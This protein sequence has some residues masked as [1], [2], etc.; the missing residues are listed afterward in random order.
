MSRKLLIGVTGSIAAYKACD[1]VSLLAQRGHQVKVIMTEN[2]RNFVAPLALET[3]SRN[4]VHVGQFQQGGDGVEHIAL[5]RWAD[6]VCIAPA[7]ADFICKYAAGFADN[8]LLTE[9][10]AFTG[11]VLIAPA[12]NHAMYESFQV[13]QAIG[14]LQRQGVGFIDP[15]AGLL[16]CGETGIG[17]MA[18]VETVAETIETTLRRQQLLAGKNVVV[19]AGPTRAYIDPVRFLSN[20]SSGRMGYALANAATAMG[21]DVTLVSGP[22]DPTLKF[23]KDIRVE[24]AEQMWQATEML[25][26]NSEIDMFVGAAAVNDLKP[27]QTAERKLPKA[28]MPQALSLTPE[29]DVI[30]KVAASARRP[31]L[32]V[33]FA[34]ETDTDFVSKAAQKLAA[35]RLDYIIANQV[36]VAGQ[37]FGSADNAVTVVSRHGEPKEFVKTDKRLLAGNL[38]EWIYADHR[39]RRGVSAPDLQ[40][41]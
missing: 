12:M 33:G 6:I 11:Q 3:L 7:S 20:P 41:L 1:L 25:L 22:C 34:A 30:A 14:T 15:Y 23:K 24:T 2:A 8:L 35:K 4:P 38:L 5:A 27:S 36:G 31:R 16:A 19:T 26:H 9:L 29:I 37:G 40:I 10:L 18:T 17:K 21:A 13:Q 32:I 28:E 39:Q